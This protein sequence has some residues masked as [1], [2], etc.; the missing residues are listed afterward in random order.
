MD[1]G[2]VSSSTIY[3]VMDY[4]REELKNE[5]VELELEE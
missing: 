3:Y 5:Q 4:M 2:N 1:Y